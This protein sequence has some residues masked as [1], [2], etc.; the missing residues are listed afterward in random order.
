MLNIASK[1]TMYCQPLKTKF[2][3]NDR[4]KFECQFK[5]NA[6]EHTIYRRNV[7][8]AIKFMINFHFRVDTKINIIDRKK[9][10]YF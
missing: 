5:Y 3:S 2:S 6:T 9:S 1:F 10:I 4:T 7:P 8:I